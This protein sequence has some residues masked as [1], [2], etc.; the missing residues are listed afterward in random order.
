MDSG[1]D[2]CQ[3]EK[4]YHENTHDLEDWNMASADAIRQ[5]KVADAGNC[6]PDGGVPLRESVR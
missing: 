1:V 2:T 3:I 5:L 4:K 6:K